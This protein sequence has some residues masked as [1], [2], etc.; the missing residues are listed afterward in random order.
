MKIC[1]VVGEVVA[2]VKH[3][4]LEGRKLLIVQPVD[5]ADAAD[6]KPLIAVDTVDA[7]PGE[8]VLLCDEGGSA[9][10]ALGRDGPIRS[11]LVGRIDGPGFGGSSL[12][13]GT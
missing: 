3:P 9:A 11:V 4:H 5:E 13:A 10:L 2:T 6:G 1:R 8:R 12:S 7:G